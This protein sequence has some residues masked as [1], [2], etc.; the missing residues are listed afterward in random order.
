[1]WHEYTREGRTKHWTD[2]NTD[3]LSTGVVEKPWWEMDNDSKSRLRHMLQ[4][5]DNKIDLGEYGLGTERTLHDYEVYG[6]FDFKKCLIQDYTLKVKELENRIELLEN[7]VKAL[8]LDKP[9]MGRPPKEKHGNE[10]LEVDTT[11]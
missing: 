2:F 5:E 7:V 8:Q 9:R 3:N 10:R 6:G 11:S 4:E 1:M